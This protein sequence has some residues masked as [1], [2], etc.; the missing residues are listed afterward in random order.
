EALVREGGP[1]RAVEDARLVVQGVDAGA[2]V[3]MLPREQ[4]TAGGAAVADDMRRSSLS[5]GEHTTIDHGKPMFGAFEVLLYQNLTEFRCHDLERALE[6]VKG[7]D[8]DVHKLAFARGVRFQHHRQDR[9]GPPPRA[10]HVFL[11]EDG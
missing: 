11:A 4:L 3:L 5:N 1:D 7:F 9:L 8:A 2:S 10:V 6:L